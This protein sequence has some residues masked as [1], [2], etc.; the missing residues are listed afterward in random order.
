MQAQRYSIPSWNDYFTPSHY[1]GCG[2]I[3]LPRGFDAEKKKV[4]Q[5]IIPWLD[6]W[7][8]T[9]NTMYD[10]WTQ[11]MNYGWSGFY[12]AR[13][14]KL[15]GYRHGLRCQECG[16][17]DCGCSCCIG[18]ADLLINSRV[19]ERRVIPF[20]IEND[21]RRERQVEL[22]LGDWTTHD[23]KQEIKVAGQLSPPLAFM[24]AA[25]SEQKLTMVVQT[26]AREDNADKLL[27]DVDGCQVYYA[28]LRVKGCD[29]RPVRI[30]LA[31]LSRDCAPFNIECRCDCC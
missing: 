5:P 31:I 4:N 26:V 11:T 30:A 15:R 25:C 9:W 16:G 22:E 23:G 8:R 12:P 27:D 24:L 19:G 3:L 14:E 29:V 20:V 28:D 1:E 21:S 7:M 10:A 17:D 6:D 2:R 18:D 13:P